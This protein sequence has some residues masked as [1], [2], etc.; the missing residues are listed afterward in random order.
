MLLPGSLLILFVFALCMK[1]PLPAGAV[2][3]QQ[4]ISQCIGDVTGDGEPLMFAI[5]GEGKTAAGESYGQILL[6]CKA[7]AKEELKRRG[8]ITSA[9]I[10]HRFDLSEIKPMKVQLGDVNGDKVQ[11]IA[12]CVYKTTKF[13]PDMEKRPFFY[14]LVEG[15][16]IP[17]WLG[18]RL[19]R[20]FEDYILTDMDDDGAD[21]IVSIERAED[22]KS[23]IA[24]YNWAGFGFE[25]LTQSQEQSGNLSFDA[26]AWDKAK[27]GEVPVIESSDKSL[28]S[29]LTFILTENDLI[30]TQIDEK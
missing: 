17:V 10:L 29:R 13:Y 6:V 23:V 11:E 20:A 5:S 3:G 16:L 8:Y 26:K 21:E 27:P 7:K 9:N 18:S 25:M 19:S 12:L 22:G 1:K 4:I 15:S 2:S 14:D 24:V 30:C 28:S